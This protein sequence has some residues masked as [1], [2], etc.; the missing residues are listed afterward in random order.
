MKSIA[1]THS[2]NLLPIS[3]DYSLPNSYNTNSNNSNNDLNDLNDQ[4]TYSNSIINPL[5]D[6]SLLNVKLSNNN[7][8]LVISSLP[9]TSPP[10]SINLHS[11]VIP[12]IGIYFDDDS[13]SIHLLLV[14][15]SCGLLRLNIPLFVLN[16]PSTENLPDG[17][18]TEY[19][20]NCADSDYLQISTVH[21]VDIGTI[22]LGMIDG[23]IIMCEQPRGN[24]TLLG[25]GLIS[26]YES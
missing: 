19:I 25:K 3:I 12:S 14:T 1:Y 10:L 4:S 22:L 11:Q 26:Y 9:T 21:P 15:Q 23:S 2:S 13:N 8:N 6:F 16:N 7:F 24:R 17:W 18:A 20:L 5:K